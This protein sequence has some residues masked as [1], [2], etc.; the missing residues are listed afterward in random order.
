MANRLQTLTIKNMMHITK[1]IETANTEGGVFKIIGNQAIGYDSSWDMSK[2]S[3]VY[4]IQSG[5]I[6]SISEG[7][8]D[9]TLFHQIKQLNKEQLELI[10]NFAESAGLF[11]A[12][13]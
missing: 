7:S 5:D 12:P 10:R 3:F 13:F 2:L 8:E 6:V 1:H 4:T 11:G 9:D